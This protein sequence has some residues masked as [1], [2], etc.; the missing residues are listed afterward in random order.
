M[1]IR[2]YLAVCTLS[3]IGAAVIGML[4]FGPAAQAARGARA[5]VVLG[6]SIGPV[7]LGDTEAYLK[8]VLGKPNVC[9]PCTGKNASWSYFTKKFDGRINFD[10]QGRVDDVY[11]NTPRYRTTKGVHAWG[12]GR[13][14]GS[15]IA[16]VKRAYPAVKCTKS[17]PGNPF[18][19]ALKGRFRGRKTV[20]AFNFYPPVSNG[21]TEIEIAYAL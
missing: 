8:A 14:K 7:V 4:T 6:R 21:V 19:C 2:R 15:S 20:T 12:G 17:F 3:A 1:G 11:T 10:A 5:N 9:D 18:P 16:A 13:V